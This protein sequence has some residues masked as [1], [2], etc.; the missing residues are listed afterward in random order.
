MKTSQEKI[1]EDNK[2]MINYTIENIIYK[3]GGNARIAFAIKC[4]LLT[5]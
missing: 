5:F 1:T 2:K 3:S 4:I